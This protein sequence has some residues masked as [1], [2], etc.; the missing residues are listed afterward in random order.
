[1]RQI[2]VVFLSCCVAGASFAETLTVFG[3]LYAEHQSNIVSSSLDPQ[4]GS[5]AR[6][7]L[8]VGGEDLTEHYAWSLNGK[9]SYQVYEDQLFSNQFYGDAVGN[10][11]WIVRPQ[12]L[13]WHF[14]YI[15]SVE[16]L[17][18]GR[19]GQEGNQ[20]SVR[21][22]GTGPV[23]RQRIRESNELV[24]SLRRQ[25]VENEFQG[26]YRSIGTATLWRDIR[27]RHRAFV[28][29]NMTRVEYGDD[30]PDFEIR[31]AG[32]GYLYEWSRLSARFEAGRAWLDQQLLGEQ[33]TDTGSI[34][35]KWLLAGGRSA[36]ARSELRYG[37]EAANLQSVPDEMLTG[38]V[39]TV[40]AFREQVHTL[41]YSGSERVAD[42]ATNLWASERR[43]Q[44]AIFSIRDTREAGIA[45]SSRLYNGN[46][47]FVLFR[48][49]GAR[50]EFLAI[51]RVDRDYSGTVSGT[52]R[53]N[54][55][56]EVIVGV[57]R[58]QRNSSVELAGFTNT[59]LFIEYRGRL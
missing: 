27:V 56:N 9:F 47:G 49:S 16:V 52:R 42:P 46:S 30:Q 33:Q 36:Q 32:V 39:D 24:I 6:A 23:F 14:D 2:A 3:S 34:R 25:R 15:E 4:A 19:I 45:M 41:Y 57:T 40:G 5:L 7:R 43:Y 48:L 44:R 50:R 58:F 37:D 35:F 31:E 51:D 8:E 10:L 18:P 11:R 13:D 20:Q 17:D 38:A 29:T 12:S 59:T 28:E 22:F 21:V 55:R 1:M 53:I 54:S 26:Y